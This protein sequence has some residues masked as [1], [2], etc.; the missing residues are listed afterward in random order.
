M[1]RMARV[2]YAAF[3][4]TSVSLF[5]FFHAQPR[6]WAVDEVPVAF[7][8][9]RTQSPNSE[10][11]RAASESV[12]AQV[13]FLRA[14]QIDIQDGKLR[15]IRPLTGSFPQGIKLHLVYNTTRAL[16]EQ[17]E[18]VDP[19]TFA[20][21]L[22]SDYRG[23]TE[24]AHRDGA[25]LSG[26]QLD[27]DFPTRLLPHYERLLKALRKDLEAN[28]QLSITGLPTWMDSP[29]LKGVLK[30]VDFWVP[31]FYGAQIPQQSN[32]FIPISAPQDV[33][34]FVNKAR[35]IDKPFYAGLAAY[36][37]ALLYS[38]SGSLISLRG[39]M[40]P[41]LIASDPNLEL[42]DQRTFD[43]AE[44]RYAFR[45]KADGVVDGLNMHGGDVLVVD[46][47]TTE[48]LRIAART[49]RKLAGK[50]LIGIC[51]FRLPARDDPATLT[52]EQVKDAL[53]DKNSY[54]RVD[55]HLT[56]K[57]AIDGTHSLL[58]EYTNSGT[59]IPVIGSL[60]L[61]LLIPAGSFAGATPKPGV[62]IQS[63]CVGAGGNTPQ[64]CSGRRANLIRLNVRSLAPG[65]TQTTT[66]TLNREPGQT[67]RVS[68]AM[69]TDTGQSYST[70]LEM[71]TGAMERT[72]GAA[73]RGRPVW[74]SSYSRSR[75]YCFLN[76]M[77]STPGGHGAPTV[78][79]MALK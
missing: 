45:A 58:L 6:V 9:W 25:V 18:A 3:I 74:N 72:V 20:T 13:V 24:H 15:R 42:I 44:H 37:V 77:S 11:L 48:S 14:G 56:R 5:S 2:V 38:A 30:N 1:S 23:D 66:L 51:V 29:A 12:K 28:D 71:P 17:L 49:V 26:M 67:T 40:D 27:I 60:Q 55:V 65:Q 34:Y 69:L 76:P 19:Q 31:Q 47:P 59:A 61:D 50:K 78:R 64:P 32:Q 33:T 73:L 63:M 79:S 68:V 46:L 22:I 75:D 43:S 36:S 53:N 4:V 21:E 16:L 7:W 39:D 57:P 10:D 41:G 62:W 52:V 70:Q 35:Q 8:A 54:A